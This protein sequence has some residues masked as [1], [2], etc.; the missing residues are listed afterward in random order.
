V[1]FRLRKTRGGIT[2]FAGVAIETDA[3]VPS[4][5]DLNALEEPT[6][7]RFE[8]ALNAGVGHALAEHERRGGSAPSVRVTALDET[9]SDTKDD[10]VRCAAAIATWQALG[11]AESDADL[12]FE[13]GEWT[14]T[15]L[16]EAS[17]E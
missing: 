6:R 14:V 9:V 11:Y 2:A 8:K 13:N 17:A 7:I 5:V 4:G 1:Y 12:R 3:N 15:F 10:A 16:G